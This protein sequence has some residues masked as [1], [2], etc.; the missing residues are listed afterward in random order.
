MENSGEYGACLARVLYIATTGTL[1]TNVT[2]ELIGEIASVLMALC[3]DNRL[4]I[5]DKFELSK[6]NFQI[7]HLRKLLTAVKLVSHPME[8]LEDSDE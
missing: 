4:R 1:H 5:K 2:K 8:L 6:I 3:I 7:Q